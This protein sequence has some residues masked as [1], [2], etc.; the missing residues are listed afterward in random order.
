MSR[1]VPCLLT[2]ADYAVLEN[3][4]E[5]HD[6]L[7]EVVVRM[8][9]SKRSSAMIVF[10]DDVP[11]T[12]ATLNSTVT[13]RIGNGLPTT[14]R[15]VADAA[16]AGEGEQPLLLGTLHGAALLGLEAG[17]EIILPDG[18]VLRLDAISEQPE[19]ATRSAV[20]A[21][22]ISLA[23][24]RRISPVA[25]RPDGGDDDDPGPRAA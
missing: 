2:T 10:S 9:R 17:E 16:R 7:D 4:I 14:A 8:L 22:V 23:S 19:A 1:D 3:L 25:S 13:Y 21:G 6:G 5:T 15:L 12:V 20:K 11:S 18:A 24:R